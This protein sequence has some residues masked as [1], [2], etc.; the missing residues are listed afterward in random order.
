MFELKEIPKPSPLKMIAGSFAKVN[1]N[2]EE[3]GFETVAYPTKY[4]D[5]ILRLKNSW[6]KRKLKGLNK[7]AI[8]ENLHNQSVWNQHLYNS[9]FQ[10]IET[11]GKVMIN[12]MDL[13]KEEA[14]LKLEKENKY[15]KKLSRKFKSPTYFSTKADFLPFIRIEGI[16]FTVEV[17]KDELVKTPFTKPGITT[18]VFKNILDG[19]I[20]R[21]DVKKVDAI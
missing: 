15:C 8:F 1:A 20:K 4:N 21:F 10:Q 5:V 11:V 17:T 13:M 18:F 12:A 7:K 14:I 9:S 2:F 19:K 16:D 6:M 3:Q